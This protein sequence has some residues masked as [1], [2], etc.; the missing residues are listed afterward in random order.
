MY[1]QGSTIGVRRGHLYVDTYAHFFPITFKSFQNFC[2]SYNFILFKNLMLYILYFSCL[3]LEKD[4]F[5]YKLFNKF[6]F[7][8]QSTCQF[9]VSVIK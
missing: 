9:R 6:F 8:P 5:P 2:S 3:S 7:L 4:Y 1:R